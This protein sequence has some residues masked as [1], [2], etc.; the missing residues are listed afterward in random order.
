V[1]QIVPAALVQGPILV[2]IAKLARQRTCISDPRWFYVAMAAWVALQLIAV[3]FS[4]AG[5]TL[6]SRYTD[7]FLIGTILNFAALLLL[8]QDRAESQ[9][10]KLLSIGAAL[11]ISVVVLGAGQKAAGPVIDGLSFRFGNGQ[12][13]TENV[14]RFVTTGDYAA[15]DKKPES[16]DIPF[17]SAATLR[18]LLTN[19]AL[20]AILPPELTGEKPR[21]PL[22]DAVLSQGPLLIP[23]GLALL[24]I[25]ATASLANPD[26]NERDRAVE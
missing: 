4:R 5:D 20:R 11:W 2:L 16:L 1:L 9:R 7:N 21:R 6:Q 22:R 17:P 8:I 25:V 19:P 24:L 26:R 12:R 14:R 10:R 18:E 23:I 3:S 13:Q 15:L